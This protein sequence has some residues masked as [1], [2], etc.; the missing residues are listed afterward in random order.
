M[1]Q[2]HVLVSTR[3]TSEQ[4]ER[5]RH[6]NPRLMIHGGSGGIAIITRLMVATFLE[7]V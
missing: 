6:L 3:V 1:K 4:L 7:V 2:T 5:M